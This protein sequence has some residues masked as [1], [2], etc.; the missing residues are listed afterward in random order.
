MVK[1]TKRWQIAFGLLALAFYCAVFAHNLNESDR[2]SID[3]KEVSSARDHVAVS[4]RVVGASPRTS[5]ITAR[6]S[7]RLQG[8]IARDPVTPAVD[9]TL[10]LNDIRGP[11]AIVWPR[12]RR[13][14]PIEASFSLTG[15]ENRYPIDSYNSEIRL[16]VTRPGHAVRAE[17]P[18]TP[19]GEGQKA[20]P[21]T[22]NDGGLVLAAEDEGQLVPVAFSIAASIPGLK[23]EGRDAGPGKTGF[24][25]FDLFM[26]RADNVIVVSVVIMI[27]MMCLSMSVLMMAIGS[28]LG[29]KMEL[30]PLSL[31]VS[32]L[33]GLPALRNA[34]PG[35]PALGALGDY[36][37]FLWAECVVAFSAVGIIWI[38]LTRKRHSG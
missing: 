12:G 22:G 5:D 6:L 14:N 37:S 23:F 4:M 8:S 33:F 9:L 20:G 24:V 26:R 28:A 2:R 19:P 18:E 16:L 34:Q 21:A 11:Q 35:V 15:N 1:A 7:F 32:L 29:E 36:V 10:F 25:G 30:V 31:S 3:V 38:W 13:I 27:L 17:Q